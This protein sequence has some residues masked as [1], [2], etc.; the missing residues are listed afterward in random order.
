MIPGMNPKQMQKM[1]KQMGIK[2]ENLDVARAEFYLLDGTKLVF[3]NPDVQK[4]KM[5][6]QE[7]YQLSGTPKTELVDST[8][9]ISDDD[10]RTVMEQTGATRDEALKAIEDTGGDLAEAIMNLVD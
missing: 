8:P 6:G 10:I 4:V 2:Q 5:M 3:D 1:M 9:E 7:T